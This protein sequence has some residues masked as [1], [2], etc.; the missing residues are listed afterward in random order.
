MQKQKGFTLIEVMVVVII[1]AILAMVAIPAY[2]RQVIKSNRVSAQAKMMDLAGILERNY[3]QNGQYTTAFINSI[4]N[5]PRGNCPSAGTAHNNRYNICVTGVTATSV[6][7][8]RQYTI[9]ATR[10]N[11]QLSDG[12][13]NLTLNSESIKGVVG[14][15]LDVETCWR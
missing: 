10:V 14:G 13:G 5:D 6:G 1:V 8:F 11:A 4:N 7:G 3:T 15:T 9:T 12:C 2:Q